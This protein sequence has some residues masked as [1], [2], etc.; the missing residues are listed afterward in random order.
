MTNLR[1]LIVRNVTIQSAAEAVAL[2]CGLASAALL[3]RHLGV[4]GFGAF[5][6][7]FAFMYFF[8]TLN[9]LGINTVAVREMSKAPE[10]AADLLA[11]LLSLRITLAVV[12]LLVTW[13]AIAI[14]PMEPALRRPLM[15]FALILPLGALNV[16]T[17]LFQVSMR[18]ELGAAAQ[19]TTRVAGVL[20]I[21][22]MIAA[23]RGVT[24]MLVALLAAE[25]CGIIVTWYLALRLGPIRWRV[26]RAVW[27]MLL[28]AA[29][30]LAVGVVLAAIVNRVDFIM[31]ERLGSLDDVGLY[32]AAYRVTSLLEKFPL[33][34]MATL[35]P[36]MSRLAVEDGSRLRRVYR[37]AFWRFAAIGLV[38]GASVVAI[39]PWLLA[40][41]FGE[42]F[43]AGAVALQWLVLATGCLYL[44]MTG[45]N[46]L[47]AVG[48]A[49]D[50][51]VAL[52][53]GSAVNI[54]L[55]AV[56]IPSRGIEGAAVATAASMVVVLLVTLV[57]VER[58]FAREQIA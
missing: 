58:H 38:L 19:V 16:P 14:W 56:L 1:A 43:R 39:A 20:F 2:A 36:V 4:T 11:G 40:T 44:A 29:V 5:N 55:N 3:S 7:V 50:N 21:L 46:L 32:G 33:F 24:A 8:L 30:P 37:N 41:A 23:G 53:L 42:P 35:Y 13:V 9:D 12:V 15:V 52:A 6:Y 45:G 31:L 18:L 47:I 48:R 25:V 51:A 26:D 34:V 49:R 27:S 57:S 10:R 17:V 22:V 28:R 54:A